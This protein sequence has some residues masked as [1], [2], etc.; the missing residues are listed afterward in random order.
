MGEDDVIARTR[1]SMTPFARFSESGGSVC[2]EALVGRIFQH[3]LH[4]E[5]FASVAL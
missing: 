5:R 1:F 4:E 2:D 3:L